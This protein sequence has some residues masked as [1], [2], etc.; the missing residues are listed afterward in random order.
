MAQRD[1]N[2]VQQLGDDEQQ[3]RLVEDRERAGRL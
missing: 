2:G 1:G 3:E